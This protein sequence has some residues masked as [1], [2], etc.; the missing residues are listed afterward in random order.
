MPP[1]NH[2]LLPAKA[3]PCGVERRSRHGHWRGVRVNSFMIMDAS[4]NPSDPLR[5]L[6]RE[7]VPEV[8][9]GVV[10]IKGVAR[11]PGARSIVVV[12]SRVPAI[13]AV[14][15][16]VGA[17]GCRIKSI[18]AGLAGEKIDIVLWHESLERFAAN[19][20]APTIFLNIALD[21][22]ARRVTL[23]QPSERPTAPM[24]SGIWALKAKLFLQ[25]TGWNLIYA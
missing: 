18:V 1:R 25:L 24:A 19:L 10:E 11:E 20:L 2:W 6:F 15:V 17:R 23:S 14:G 5:Q 9:T 3:N 21:A 7:H 4:L 13:D 8:A 22:A 12:F 16:C